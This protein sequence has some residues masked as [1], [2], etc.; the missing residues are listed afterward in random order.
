[1]HTVRVRASRAPRERPRGTLG[2]AIALVLLLAGCAALSE[3]VLGRRLSSGRSAAEAD[4]EELAALG[5]YL[6]E[7]ASGADTSRLGEPYVAVLP[8]HSRSSFP[9]DIWDLELG[10]A[11][12]LSARMAGHP[13]WHVVPFPAVADVIG[14]SSARDP[15]RLVEAGRVLQ[16]DVMV[17]G[18]IEKYDVGRFSVGDPLLGGYKSYTGIAHLA[19]RVL[20]VTDGQDL[21]MVETR[22]E[23]VDRGMGLDL[24]G[25]PRDQDLQFTGLRTIGFG[26][27]EFE[28]IP[29]G[30]ATAQALD[31][32]VEQL[33][34]LLR[35]TQPQLEGVTP[36]ILSAH[37]SE[38]FINVGS[39]NG[40]HPGC[41]FEVFAGPARTSSSQLDGQERLGLI[42]VEEVV[43]ARLSRV[44]VIEA[45]ETMRAGDILTLMESR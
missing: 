35:P 12:M 21:G 4:L 34:P 18:T 33:A 1:M 14:S 37:G 17:V 36:E 38:V 29:I 9:S 7:R 15:T 19:L 20:R 11:T 27:E 31:D 3:T 41:R 39:Q 25:R 6:S 44:S 13:E 23:V 8:F 10:M 5:E 30:R 22:Q 26:T 40:I 24:L 2:V 32:L 42:E 43:A 45:K 16:A 28:A